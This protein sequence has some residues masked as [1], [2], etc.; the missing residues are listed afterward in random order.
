MDTLFIKLPLIAVMIAAAIPGGRSMAGA[1]P[2]KSREPGGGTAFLLIDIQNDYFPGGKFE[3]H[4]AGKAGNTAKLLLA[5]F[6][7]M[8]VPVLHIR[9]ESIRPGAAFFIPG[10]PGADIHPLV[11]PAEGETVILKHE[12]SSF[13]GTNLED[14]L[15]K[16]DIKTLVIC[17][18]Q[19]NVCVKSTALDAVRMKYTVIVAEDA[20]AA[21]SEEIHHKAVEEMR[22][23]GVS[24]EDA[25]GIKKKLFIME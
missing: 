10:T 20:I 6:R 5:H 18:M 9:H 15:G 11:S 17:G 21:R 23:A 7:K 3:L 2:K 14:E 13:I 16:R 22:A 25:S 19:S 4:E 8:K 1:A 24:I 12:P